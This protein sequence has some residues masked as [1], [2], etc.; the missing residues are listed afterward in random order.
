[1]KFIVILYFDSLVFVRWSQNLQQWWNP[2]MHYCVNKSPPLKPDMSQLNSGPTFKTC[3][4]K[5]PVDNTV[6][7]MSRFYVH[8]LY[9]FV[10]CT[11]HAQCVL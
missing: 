6:Q 10:Y 4:S 7:S 9:G 11:S 3:S 8:N 5:I 2:D 1:M